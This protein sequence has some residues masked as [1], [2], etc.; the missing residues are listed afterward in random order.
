MRN[1]N[2][3]EDKIITYFSKPWIEDTYLD[4]SFIESCENGVQ[5]KAY[6]QFL[7]SETICGNSNKHRTECIY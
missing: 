5:R 2:R 4:I 3:V 6:S 1:D 7:A